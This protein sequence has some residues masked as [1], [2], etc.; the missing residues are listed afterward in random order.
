[1]E[2][3]ENEA[4]ALPDAINYLLKH[5]HDTKVADKLPK[6]ALAAFHVITMHLGQSADLIEALICLRVDV[7]EERDGEELALLLQKW[8]IPTSDASEFGQDFK[9]GRLCTVHHIKK[10]RNAIVEAAGGISKTEHGAQ[11]AEL[12]DALLRTVQR[13][14]DAGVV[15][16][17]ELCAKLDGGNQDKKNTVQTFCLSTPQLGLLGHVMSPVATLLLAA[18]VG[19]ET[20]AFYE[21]EFERVFSHLLPVLTSGKVAGHDVTLRFVCDMKNLLMLLGMGAVYKA[22]SKCGCCWCL[23]LR[24]DFSKMKDCK[25]RTTDDVNVATAAANAS[26]EPLKPIDN[27]GFKSRNLL[28]ELPPG[29]ELLSI[30]LVDALHVVLNTG[31]KILE[32]AM[33]KVG[34]NDKKNIAVLCAFFKGHC[35]VVVLDQSDKNPTLAACV[36]KSVWRVESNFLCFSHDGRQKLLQL[37]SQVNYFKVNKSKFKLASDITNRL[38]ELWAVMQSDGTETVLPFTK[39]EFGA[40]AEEMGT[41]MTKCYGDMAWT[42]YLHVLIKHVP[43]CFSLVPNW[44][45]W[46]NYDIEGINLWIKGQNVN[47]IGHATAAGQLMKNRMIAE[48]MDPKKTSRQYKRV[49]EIVGK[50]DKGKQSVVERLTQPAPLKKRKP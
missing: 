22:N 42:T 1:M 45:R 34:K 50:K 29:K 6:K 4:C 14:V 38:G 46:A 25:M 48:K 28:G 30:F 39:A 36:S 26:D 12:D 23:V 10:A 24:K 13:C 16:P 43:Q 37:L 41:W 49:N 33:Q 8:K 3:E 18:A 11:L 2:E 32:L 9:C 19:E 17:A 31:R 27:D 20:A 35:G 21:A 7:K 44:H 5:A 47:S 40:R 15:S